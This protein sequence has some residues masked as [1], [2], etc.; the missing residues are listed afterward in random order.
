M[1]L[2]VEELSICAWRNAST[3]PIDATSAVSFCSPMKSLSNGGIT[4]RMACGKI[5]CRSDFIGRVRANGCRA[6]A[7]VHRL[8]ARAIDLC[9]VGGVHEHQ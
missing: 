5:T 6:L 7:L 1:K 8:D 9:D 2:N 3:T 4:R